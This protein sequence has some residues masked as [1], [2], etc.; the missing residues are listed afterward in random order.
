MIELLSIIIS[1]WLCGVVLKLL[2]EI[3]WGFAKLLA[4]LLLILALPAL[5]GCLLTVGGL[6][7][8]LPVGMLL[9]AIMILKV[10][11]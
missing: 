7:M 11:I 3:A 4:I 10:F 1:L 9:F 2:G 5:V 6:L 8:L